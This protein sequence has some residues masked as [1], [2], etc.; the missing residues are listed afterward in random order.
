MAAHPATPLPSSKIINEIRKLDQLYSRAVETRDLETLLSLYEP[1]ATVLPPHAPAASTQAD[2]RNLFQALMAL[3]PRGFQINTTRVEEAG[4][5]AIATGTFRVALRDIEDQGK[6]LAV[7]RR[8]KKG[9]LR[10][11]YDTWNSDLPPIV[12]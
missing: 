8:N 1:N 2:V 9:D 5:L 6:F 11:V 10:L 4:D 12:T 7:F 3:E